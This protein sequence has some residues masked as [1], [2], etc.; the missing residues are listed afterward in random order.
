MWQLV[1]NAVSHCRKVWLI[2]RGPKQQSKVCW[3]QDLTN[4]VRF[5][6]PRL[7]KSGRQVKSFG[8]EWRY[9]G[10]PL[11]QVSQPLHTNFCPSSFPANTGFEWICDGKEDRVKPAHTVPENL[12]PASTNSCAYLYEDR[13]SIIVRL[14][15]PLHHREGNSEAG[16]RSLNLHCQT[17]LLLCSNKCRK[18]P[19]VAPELGVSEL[20]ERCNVR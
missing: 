9:S 7:P 18:L 15:Q 10:L 13:L 16:L 20:V 3:N 1:H 4:E 19:R 17:L 6:A 11:M 12:L 14:S 2:S 5:S 8:S